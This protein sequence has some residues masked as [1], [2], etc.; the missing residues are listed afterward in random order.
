MLRAQA[1]P[2]GAHDAY[3]AYGTSKPH[4][5]PG[6]AAYEHVD[7]VFRRV[8]NE[9]ARGRCLTDPCMI[10]TV[11]RRLDERSE[12]YFEHYTDWALVPLYRRP[13]AFGGTMC[14]RRDDAK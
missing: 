4:G 5:P 1:T 12:K 3:D 11:R 10:C 9:V 7:T 8:Y 13:K 2:S 6:P 14:V